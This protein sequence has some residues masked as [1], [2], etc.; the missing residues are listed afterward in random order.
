[1]SSVSLKIDETMSQSAMLQS[2]IT[3]EMFINCNVWRRLLC[4]K[5]EI[6]FKK[7]NILQLYFFLLYPKKN[8]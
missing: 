3:Y 4:N 7:M 6:L 2:R 1:M 5:T 8:N